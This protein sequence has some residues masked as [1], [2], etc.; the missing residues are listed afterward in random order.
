MSKRPIVWI[1]LGLAGA[2]GYY[3]YSAGGDPKL[4]QK[5]IECTN[6]L[7]ERIQDCLANFIPSGT[8]DYQKAEAKIRGDASAESERFK[9]EGET[10]AAK[11]GQKFDSAVR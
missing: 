11:A 8:A 3:L 7:S 9:K 10:A 1:G 2:G 5:N 4:A 6:L